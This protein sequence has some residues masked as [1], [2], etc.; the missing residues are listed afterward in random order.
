VFSNGL[1]DVQR[2]AVQAVSGPVLVLAGAGS[3]KTRVLTHKIAHLIRDQG[4]PPGRILA[5]TFTN[6]A[7]E[8]M[9]GRMAS[10]LDGQLSGLWMGTFHATCVRILRQNAA[11]ASLPRSFSIFDRDDAL[12]VV[13]AR[14]K[15][16]NV[17]EEEFTPRFVLERISAAKSSA[18][19][20]DDLAASASSRWLELVADLYRHYEEELRAQQALDFDDLLLRTLR[21]LADHEPVRAALSG[22]FLHV[23]V[24][25]YQDTNKVQF[26][27]TRFLAGTHRNLTVV[28]DDDQSIYGW[29]GADIRNILDFERFFPEATVFRL[30]QNYRSTKRILDAANAVVGNNVGR[31]PKRLWTNNDE[32]EPLTLTLAPDEDREAEDIVRHLVEMR[33]RGEL[34]L[35]D[36]AVLFRT[37]AQSR[38]LEEA[39]L[40]FR[41]PYRIVGGVHFF[42]RAEVKDVLA[43]LKLAA[44]PR[45][46]VAFERAAQSPK[47]GIG[48][49]SLD[50]LLASSAAF[51]GDL[52]EA[53]CQA[54]FVPGLS[55]KAADEVM[56]FG[57]L[58]R[59]VQRDAAE[60]S[61]N[62][63]LEAVIRDS[64]MLEGLLKAGPEASSRRENLEELVAGA[65]AF[66]VRTGALGIEQYLEEMALRTDLDSWDPGEDTISLMTV[67]N[68]KG[69]EF[70]VVFLAGLEERLFPHSSSIET[71]EGLEEERRLFYVA[72]TRARRK[73]FLSATVGQ[74]RILRFESSEPSRFLD[75][76]PTALLERRDPWGLGLGSGRYSAHGTR[77][78]R[79]SRDP[80]RVAS[81]SGTEHGAPKRYRGSASAPIGED[82]P[83]IDLHD[84]RGSTEYLG[85]VVWHAKYG[86]GCVVA[87]EGSGESAKCEVRF[88][89]QTV[90]KI[91]ARFLDF[92]GGLDEP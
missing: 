66:A 16:M 83:V 10:L 37:N 28:G 31:K 85:R 39:C 13:K 90:R 56:R 1:N 78:R 27:L 25:E 61:V 92:E 8:E 35:P 51:G 4:V 57:A 5:F 87:Q 42:G 68:A 19:T 7:A 73:L 64:G 26:E 12:S 48:K 47:R 15:A 89:G 50:R 53:A 65:Q 3:G 80:T 41:V 88:L 43:Y 62:E 49:V 46:A 44:N 6:K 58:I 29:R 81:G 72:V 23:L 59:S 33:G 30:E 67:H 22:R 2:E 77:A 76:I 69:L 38:P 36:A 84:D 54:A 55:G 74:R 86:R 79:I 71:T 20:P 60:K 11:A 34:R 75:E 70:D 63:I 14:I 9:R 40:R 91:V 32:G 21:L 52:V 24:D 82:G 17:S 18:L 45:D